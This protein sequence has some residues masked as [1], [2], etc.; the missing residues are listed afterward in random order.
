MFSCIHLPNLLIEAALARHPGLHSHPCAVVA[1]E[2]RPDDPK[3]PLLA[4]NPAAA[5]HGIQTGESPVRAR[6]RC[7]DLRFLA[8]DPETEQSLQNILL[9]LA[10]SLS[11]DFERHQPDTLIMDLAGG[12]PPT[13]WNP[14]LPHIRLALAETPDLAHLAAMANLPFSGRLL[15]SADFDP[16]PLTILSLADLP[17]HKAFLPIF[18][19]WGL[20][21][22]SDFRNL[23]QQEIAERMGPGA[24]LLHNIL[25]GKTRRLLKL[26]RPIESFVQS[27]H[28]ET[29]LESLEPLVFQ[30][31]RMLQTL[32]ARLQA[33]HRAAGKL[34]FSLWFESSGQIERTLVLPEPLSS[35][36]ALLRP[37]HTVFETL[38][39]PTGIVAMELEL[40]SV[41]PLSAQREWLGRQL[42]Q[43]ARWPNTMARL[44]ALLGPNQVGIPQPEDSHHPDAFRVLPASGNSTTVP[45][46]RI[47]TVPP[48]PLRRFRPPLKVA[49][50]HSPH[51]TR[52]RPLALLTGPHPGTITSLRGPF[53][54]SGDWW[55]PHTAWQRLEWDI[56][57]ESRHLLRLIHIPPDHWQLDGAYA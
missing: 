47:S 46:N 37:L 57:L 3:S 51:G 56:E 7:P 8:R 18:R 11:P 43:P 48:L 16:L 6:T 20:H 54:L 12:R 13:T 26:H 39:A 15:E 29:P 2:G 14:P 28:F 27:I 24:T 17:G 4:I 42:R 25:H 5:K 31:N 30:A 21:S 35:P 9:E 23:P 33:S 41:L 38:C 32:C 44:E 55:K 52:P 45:E 34:R 53:P 50:A 36:T 10:E 19:L 49:V 1:N 22:L 40:E